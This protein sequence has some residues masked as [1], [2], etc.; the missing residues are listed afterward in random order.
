MKHRHPLLHRLWRIALWVF[1]VAVLALLARA[2]SAIDW[3]NVLQSMARYDAGT[4]AI[5][6]MLTVASYLVY[7]CYDLAARRYA[8]HLLSTRR[9]MLITGIAYAFALNIG[10]LVGGAGARFRMYSHAGLGIAAISRIVVFS[11]A[12]NW[13]GYLLLAGTL[14][15]SGS[16]VLPPRFVA[17]AGGLQAVGLAMV[18]AALLYLFACHRLHGRVF[19]LRGHHFRL[20]SVPLALVQFALAV[21]NWSLMATVVFVL[22]PPSVGYPTVLGALLFAAVATAL[23]HVP[24]GL[25]VVEAVFVAVFRHQ[26]PP[27]QV[28]A[29]LLAFRAIYFLAPLVLAGLAYFLVEVRGRAVAAASA[30]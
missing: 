2:A 17:S 7:C 23:A 28:L 11:A 26:F 22:L 20:P 16:V 13:L 4:L 9:V 25:G 8:H 29:A 12:T 14:F 1:P 3:K 19:H 24:A 18:V 30:G 10:A 15:A 6:A 27:A 21:T 5:A